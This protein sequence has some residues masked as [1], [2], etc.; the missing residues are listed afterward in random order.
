MNRRHIPFPCG[1]AML[2]GTL[3][4]GEAS[5]GLLIVSGGNEIRSGAFS[6]QARL[7]AVIAAKGYP[8][9]RFDRR[10]IGDSEG[11]NH[12][13]R[14]SRADI[15]AAIA[16]FRAQC[17]SMKR[18]VAFGNCD[19][20]SA[21]M[22]IGGHGCDAL[23]LSNPWTLD[24]LADE[25]QL[26]PPE[27]VRARYATKLRNPAEWHRLLS[28]RVSLSRLFRG[29][30]SMFRPSARN[31]T[32]IREMQKAMENI[33]ISYRFLVAGND[34]TGQAFAANWSRNESEILLCEGAT[35]AF[36]EPHAYEW[37]L[38]QLLSALEA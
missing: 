21:L 16:T 13:F 33:D 20:A 1:D 26:P 23:V 12:G 11:T 29:I 30:A 5:T 34:R 32:L 3:D 15:L 8:V 4:V 24:D 19:A 31:R 18:L 6:G 28:G 38:E 2:V 27:I 17:P 14:E 35:H 36:V 10:G 7:A 9:F 37:L 25:E 22:M